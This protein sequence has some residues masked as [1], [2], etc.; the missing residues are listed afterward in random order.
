[1]SKTNEFDLMEWS[2]PNLC[3]SHAKL[4]V[5]GYDNG[6]GDGPHYFNLHIDTCGGGDFGASMD[7]S[8]Q[9]IEDLRKLSES[10]TR[11]Y[12]KALSIKEQNESLQRST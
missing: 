1:M 2:A 6:D 8:I 11:A 9:S 4:E 10:F 5:K 7:I 3:N 12:H